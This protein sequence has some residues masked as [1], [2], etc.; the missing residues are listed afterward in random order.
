MSSVSHHGLDFAI[1]AG[2]R[3][4]RRQVRKRYRSDYEPRPDTDMR[5]LDATNA[6]TRPAKKAQHGTAYVVIDCELVIMR[7]GP[8]YDRFKDR[9]VALLPRLRLYLAT[10]NKIAF[11]KTIEQDFSLYDCLKVTIPE[12]NPNPQRSDL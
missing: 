2:G 11:L 3:C 12:L 6:A 10:A 7:H 1:C 9:G 8:V 4:Q 5:N